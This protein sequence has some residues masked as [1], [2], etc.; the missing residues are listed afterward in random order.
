MDLIRIGIVGL[1]ANTRLRHV[2]GLQ[3]C[4]NV[5]IVG[6][7]NRS[8]E[9]TQVA[10]AEFDIPKTYDDWE[11]LVADDQIDAVV[12]GTWPYLHCPITCA[13]LDAGKHVLTEARM[14]MNAREAHQMLAASREHPNLVAQIVPSPFGLRGDGLVKQLLNDGRIG[15]LREAVVLATNDALIDINTPLH[16]RQVAKYSGVNAL[17]LGILHETLIRWVP[18]PIR[19]QAQTQTFVQQRVDPVSGKVSCVETPDSVHVLTELPNGARGLYHLSGVICHGPPPQIRLHGTEGSIV[20]EFAP[21][22]RLLFARRGEELTEVKL[23]SEEEAGWRVEEEF[24]GAIGGEEQVMFTDFHTGVRYM[25]FTEAV[26][27]SAQTGSAVNPRTLGPV[28]VTN[29]E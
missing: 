10:A 16:W 13:A 8:A 29:T 20:Y 19:V 28:F 26:T 3:A 4:Q 7:C 25:A 9:S 18:D 11:S 22:E 23:P 12:I 2:P 21:H 6:V 5:E 27:L 14:A 1:G 15:E 24:I 17:L